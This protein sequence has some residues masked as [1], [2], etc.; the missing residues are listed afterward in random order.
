MYVCF[1]IIPITL[2]SHTLLPQDIIASLNHIFFF[3]SDIPDTLVYLE[4]RHHYTHTINSH[5]LAT[6]QS[7]KVSI[8]FAVCDVA[9]ETSSKDRMKNDEP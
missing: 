3:G 7:P 2:F 4:G 8:F 9:G 5:I 6:F 1:P